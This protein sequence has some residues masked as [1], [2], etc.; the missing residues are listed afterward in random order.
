MRGQPA[1]GTVQWAAAEIKHPTWG[2]DAPRQSRHLRLAQ[3]SQRN[4]HAKL[5]ISNTISAALNPQ[6]AFLSHFFFNRCQYV[7]VNTV[8]YSGR[9]VPW[10]G[11]PL[12]KTPKASQTDFNHLAVLRLLLINPDLRLICSVDTGV[13]L[14]RLALQLQGSLG[15]SN[16]WSATKVQRN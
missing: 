14:L 5:H 7:T 12:N 15:Q 10:I 8:I 9:G 2:D 16:H 3:W 6:P 13:K 4:F 1:L 11:Q